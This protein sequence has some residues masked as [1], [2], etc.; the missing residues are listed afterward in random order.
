MCPIARLEAVVGREEIIIWHR[1]PKADRSIILMYADQKH[2]LMRVEGGRLI[3]EQ[4]FDRRN[5][6]SDDG[7]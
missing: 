7:P 2:S 4:T 1:D 5:I 3:E 6:I